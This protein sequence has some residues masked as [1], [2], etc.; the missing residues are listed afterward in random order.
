MSRQLQLEIGPKLMVHWPK[1]SRH[2]PSNFRPPRSRGSRNKPSPTS[3]SA[4]GPTALDAP[5]AGSKS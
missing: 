5:S 1:V 4:T 2:W 3:M